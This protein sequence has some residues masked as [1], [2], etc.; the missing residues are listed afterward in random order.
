MII[1]DKVLEPY[2][3]RINRDYY[4]LVELIQ[5]ESDKTL[6]N[7]KVSQ[8][9]ERENVVGYYNKLVPALNRAV[10]LLILRGKETVTLKEYIGQVE[11][12]QTSIIDA[13]IK[14]KIEV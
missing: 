6:P 3:L 11:R 13:M 8:K 7:G 2:F 12:I 9:G 1:K 14:L 4:E 10:Y 5:V